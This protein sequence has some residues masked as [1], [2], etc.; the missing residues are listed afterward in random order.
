MVDDCPS[1]NNLVAW[2]AQVASKTNDSSDDCNTTSSVLARDFIK[3]GLLSVTSGAN[4][5]SIK[6]GIDKKVLCL[7]EEIE[8]RATSVKCRDDTTGS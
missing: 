5:V 7:I 6:Q 2:I 4:P 3:R 1:G 8:K